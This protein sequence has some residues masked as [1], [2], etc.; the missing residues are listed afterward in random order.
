VTTRAQLTQMF[1]GP[2]NP[3]L[4]N[5]SFDEA[6]NRILAQH[7]RSP[8]TSASS[9]IILVAPD[10]DALCASKMLADLLKQDEILHRIIPVSGI[11][12]L[13]RW[14]D[15]LVSYK[16]VR[17]LSHYSFVPLQLKKQLRQLHTLILLNM[18]AIL[19][20][21]SEDWFGGFNSN[22]TV[23]I[24]DSNRPQNLSTLFGSGDHKIDSRIILWDDGGA[25]NMEELR[26]AWEFVL[27]RVYFVSEIDHQLRVGKYEPEP[28]DSDSD[29]DDLHSLSSDGNSDED[30]ELNKLNLGE[31][32]SSGRK[33]SV[34]VFSFRL[35]LLYLI[36]NS[37]IQTKRDFQNAQD[38]NNENNG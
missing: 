21:P 17:R 31:G 13:E 30:E 23:H 6:Y 3:A 4:K 9:V 15:D 37:L 7:R 35:K 32:S 33:R 34:K 1:L 27:V 12:E 29:S 14:R 28:G 10:V 19:D 36:C 22:L 11:A 5:K 38:V 18:G 25:D 8:M 16:E 26:K 20:L 2:P 24:I